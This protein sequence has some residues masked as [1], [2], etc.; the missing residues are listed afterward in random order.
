MC[1]VQAVADAYYVLSDK[2]RRRE[3]DALYSTR[4]TS[5]KTDAPDA[6]ANFFANFANMF[7]GAAGAGAGSGA[8]VP[9]AAGHQPDAETTFADVFDDVSLP[10]LV[11]VGSVCTALY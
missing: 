2:T 6:S 8:D 11:P 10:S 1:I 5:E 7:T 9:P 4:S 3:Y